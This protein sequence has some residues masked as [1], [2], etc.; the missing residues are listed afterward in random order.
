MHH[1]SNLKF[2]CLFVFNIFSFIFFKYFVFLF[3]TKESHN[4][5]SKIPRNLFNQMNYR[6]IF[7]TQ[8]CNNFID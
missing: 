1:A 7:I 4:H 5:V 3:E 6:F 2:V 8:K